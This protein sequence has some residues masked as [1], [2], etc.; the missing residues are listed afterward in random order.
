MR[1]ACGTPDAI[2]PAAG[3]LPVRSRVDRSATVP[4]MSVEGKLARWRRVREGEIEAFRAL[5]RRL[6]LPA[7]G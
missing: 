2:G 7:V 1:G 6:D 4:S 5:A 3:F